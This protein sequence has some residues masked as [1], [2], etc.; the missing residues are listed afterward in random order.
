MTAR[1]LPAILFGP[2]AGALVDGLD[3]RKIMMAADIAR[4]VMYALMAFLDAVC[5][6]FVLS[7]VIE[8]LS[9]LW[10][11]ARDATPAEPRA[12]AAARQRE[13]ARAASAR[14]ARS[15]SA[16]AVA[17]V[18]ATIS[19]A[20]GQ[21]VPYFATHTESLAL[22]LDAGT[23]GFSAFMVTG[24]PLRGARRS[25]RRRDAWTCAGSGAT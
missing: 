18:L 5:P 9:L 24:V 8:C 6:I 21:Q 11:P 2:F 16:A 10:T 7:F 15:R 12:A 20:I 1:T 3:R 13:L 23:F 4:G 17:L 25:R 19:A 22:W 14:T